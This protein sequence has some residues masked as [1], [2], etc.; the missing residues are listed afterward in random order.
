MPAPVAGEIQDRLD[1]QRQHRALDRIAAL[2]AEH[3][4]RLG[5]FVEQPAID[6]RGQILTAFGGK[7]ETAFDRVGGRHDVCSAR[8]CRDE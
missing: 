6:Q 5:M 1:G 3:R 7:F 2:T 8:H 4:L